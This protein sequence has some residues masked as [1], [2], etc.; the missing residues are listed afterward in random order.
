MNSEQEIKICTC[1]SEQDRQ[2]LTGIGGWLIVVVLHL[3]SMLVFNASL[4]IEFIYDLNIPITDGSDVKLI[5]LVLNSF[6]DVIVFLMAA[7]SLNALFRKK[8]QFRKYYRLF[9][10]SCLLHP[11]LFASLCFW[12]QNITMYSIPWKIIGLMFLY[13]LGMIFICLPYLDESKRVRLTLVN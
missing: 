8:Y 11:L 6:V 7:F 4:F 3:S 2:K 9:I 1:C 5:P 10:L 13:P 12:Y